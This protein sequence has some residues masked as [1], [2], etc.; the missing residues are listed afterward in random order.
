[1]NLIFKVSDLEYNTVF[2]SRNVVFHEI[3]FPFVDNPIKKCI[4]LFGDSLLPSFENQNKNNMFLYDDF[5]SSS[6]EVCPVTE[7]VNDHTPLPSSS[8]SS[9]PSYAQVNNMENNLRPHRKIRASSYL[10]QYH[11]SNVVLEP[12]SSLHGTSHP[13]SSY[14]SYDK[15][16]HEYCLFCFSIISEKELRTFK[17]AVLLRQWLDAMDMELD[18]LMSTSTWVIFS[19]P[20]GKHAI[21]CKWVFKIKYKLDGCIE[22][23]KAR[24]VAKGYTQ[25]EGVDYIETFSPLAKLTTV[26]MVLA[27]AA[28]KGWSLNQM[29]VT[30]AFLHGDLDKE[31]YM[32]LPQGYSPRQK[33]Q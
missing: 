25:Q 13:L 11:C 9:S 29:D 23:Y 10:S 28:I 6:F 1:M 31:I 5:D 12:C 15:F 14:L 30:N 20:K 17:E 16:S 33:E 19:L 21:G 24:L 8:S 2:V 3:I 26:R 4:S 18:A 22:S 27:L 32:C 7:P